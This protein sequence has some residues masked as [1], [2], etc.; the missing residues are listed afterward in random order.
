MFFESY[1][2][3][4]LHSALSFSR[5]GLYARRDKLIDACQENFTLL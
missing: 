4:Y 5:E 1:K 3:L 2:Y